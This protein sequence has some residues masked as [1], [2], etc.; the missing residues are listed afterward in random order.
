MILFQIMY[1]KSPEQ[2]KAQLA[3]LDEIMKKGNMFEV[4]RSLDE[5]VDVTEWQQWA[6][7]VFEKMGFILDENHVLV[8]QIPKSADAHKL[9]D[10]FYKVWRP[11]AV[12]QPGEK[13]EFAKHLLAHAIVADDKLM[14][15]GELESI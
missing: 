4:A 14:K 11:W 3:Q 8:A 12:T 1:R 6:L 10:W 5:S 2:A 7:D 13:G 15:E 9:H